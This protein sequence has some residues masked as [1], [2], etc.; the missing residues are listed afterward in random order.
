M[1][2]I[3]FSIGKFYI[4]TYGVMLALG[5]IAGTAVAMWKARKLDLPID[6]LMDI[7]FFTI[8][9]GIAG[10]RIT[11]LIVYFDQFLETPM[12]LILSREGFVF[13]G[14]VIGAVLMALWLIR[15]YRLPTWQV[16]D[17]L[18]TG[19]P[20][21]HAFGRIG[22]FLAGCCYGRPI[23]EG[24][25]FCGIGMCFPRESVSGSVTYPGQAFH[26]H[27]LDFGLLP[28]AATSLPVW[29]TQLFESAGNFLIFLILL[30]IWRHRRFRGQLFVSYLALYGVLR[31]VVEM[32]RGDPRGTVGILSTSQTISL[33]MLV[34]AVVGWVVLSRAPQTEA[35]TTGAAEP[36]VSRANRRRKKRGRG[37]DA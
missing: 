33:V 35:P 34:C 37:H 11:Y 25:P 10:G 19:L 29:P 16:A 23:P 20:L 26:Q 14:G 13:L 15:R 5:L 28:D 7:I 22:C 9:A 18:I 2:P 24:S 6:R 32:F 36:H 3:L 4:G 30:L 21:G 17:V 12:R 1:H 31:F 27:V 8:L